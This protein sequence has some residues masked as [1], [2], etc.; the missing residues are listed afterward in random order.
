MDI[1][2]AGPSKYEYEHAHKWITE[3]YR[4][5]PVIVALYLSSLFALKH[6]M[7]DRKAFGL[8]KTLLLW[9]SGLA[10]FSM[11]GFY[12][13]LMEFIEIYNQ[14][15]FDGTYCK[16]G[17]FFRGTTGYWVWLFTVSKI[18]ELGDSYF[19]VLRKRPLT[20]LQY[21]HHAL[22][23]VYCWWS[24]TEEPAFNRIGTLS[25]YCVHSVM[26]TYFLARSL[27]M[28]IPGIIAQFVTGIQ[29]VQFIISTTLLCYGFGQITFNGMQCD[30]PVT[31]G[32]YAL[33]MNATYLYLFAEFFYR[34]YIKGEHRKHVKAE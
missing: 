34:A 18:I 1:L 27:R 17:K 33:L 32:N 29:I 28:A 31:T 3:R 7:K 21:Y 25:N 30:W 14:Y 10:V 6:Y 16:A 8:Q 11:F 13:V 22:T 19:L 24:F 26:Y 12:N 5:A 9:N 23:L 20:F 15:G 2:L 4:W